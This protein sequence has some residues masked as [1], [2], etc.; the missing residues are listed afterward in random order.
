MKWCIKVSISQYNF[1][2]GQLKAFFLVNTIKPD[3]RG[4]IYHNCPNIKQISIYFQN[5]YQVKRHIV[6]SF[7]NQLKVFCLCERNT[8]LSLIFLILSKFPVIYFFR[9]KYVLLYNYLFL[10]KRFAIQTTVW[11]IKWVKLQG[12]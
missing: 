12:L 10:N 2:Q 7:S 3:P 9:V 5:I 11:Q 6:A 8:A 1:T 4:R